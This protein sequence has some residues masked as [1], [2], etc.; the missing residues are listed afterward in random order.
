MIQV[1]EVLRLGSCRYERE[2]LNE[3]IDMLTEGED[4]GK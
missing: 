4:D 3:I 1:L 2:I